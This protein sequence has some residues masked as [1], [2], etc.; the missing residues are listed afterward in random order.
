MWWPRRP[1]SGMI[2]EV[3]GFLFFCFAIQV[4]SRVLYSVANFCYC[5]F[6]GEP[7]NTALSPVNGERPYIALPNLWQTG[8]VRYLEYSH[9][10]DGE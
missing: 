4:D 8:A 3:A 2:P 5:L 6:V 7:I 1:Q 9:A 10:S